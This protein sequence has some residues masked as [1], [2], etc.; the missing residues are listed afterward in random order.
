MVSL[1]QGR[2]PQLACAGV[3]DR[4]R[5]DHSERANVAIRCLME[6][7]S[8]RGA[9]A[10]RQ[11]C[12]RRQAKPAMPHCCILL[13][14]I[15][16]IW[17]VAPPSRRWRR[18]PAPARLDV[19]QVV[20]GLLPRGVEPDLCAQVHSGSSRAPRTKHL[21]PRRRPCGRRA[22][23]QRREGGGRGRTASR[24]ACPISTG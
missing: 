2:S 8:G 15:I 4:D 18:G 21:P 16:V 22:E 12:G 3:D 9:A 13:C 14:M 5:G 10:D 1:Y 6:R 23:G 19:E 20:R 24:R 11:G 7:S 17:V